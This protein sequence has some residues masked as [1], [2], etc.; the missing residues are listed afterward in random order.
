MEILGKDFAQADGHFLMKGMSVSSLR[1][2]IDTSNIPK[3]TID[4]MFEYS[5]ALRAYGKP[6]RSTDH[7][8]PCPTDMKSQEYHEW[9]IKR[10]LTGTYTHFEE[11][12]RI[13]WFSDIGAL[14]G[15]AGYAWFKGKYLYSGYCVI[16]S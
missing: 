4:G 1:Y 9:H 3:Y 12:D 16:R 10:M 5:N 7:S 8:I 14:S 2:E 15:G 6:A 11:G 13:F